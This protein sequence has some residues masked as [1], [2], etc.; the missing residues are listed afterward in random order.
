MVMGFWD[1]YVPGIG[2]FTGHGRI[3]DHWFQHTL[4]AHRTNGRDARVGQPGAIPNDVP[5][6]ID[7][8]I[9]PTTGTWREGFASFADFVGQTYHYQV[10]TGP[11]NGQDVGSHNDFAWARVVQEVDAGRPFFWCFDEHCVVGIGY[12]VDAAGA[13]WVIYLDTY[14]ATLTQ[15]LAEL[16]HTEGNGFTWLTL[17]AGD[18]P[19]DVTLLDPR[20]GEHVAASTPAAATWF[21]DG[22]A[23]SSADVSVSHDAGRSWHQIGPSFPAVS[24]FASFRWLPAPPQV[25]TRLRVRTFDHGAYLA[26]D[27]S[28]TDV[29]CTPQTIGGHW[30]AISGPVDGVVA[31]YD[32]HRGTRTIFTTEPGTGDV[33]QFQGK[34]GAVW[35]WLRVGGPGQAF[36]LDGSGVLYGLSP[37]G[38]GIWRY[39]GVG[40]TWT[41]IGGP[42]VAIHPDVDGV[43]AIEPGTGDLLRYLGTPFSWRRVG[44]PGASFAVDGKGVIYGVSPDHGALWRYTGLFGAVVPWTK[45]SGPTTQVF[46]RGLGVYA[47]NPDGTIRFF[48]GQPDVWTQVGGPGKAFTVDTEG[49]LYGLSSN[50]DGVWRYEG[51]ATDPTHWTKIGGAAGLVCAGHREVLA[52]NPSTRELWAYVE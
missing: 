14:G 32:K 41:H 22:T 15:K 9:D 31:G 27:G 11:T 4:W 46:A 40:T 28:V 52:T 47:T 39:G 3:V 35:N 8:L 13:K 24:G 36:V 30:V 44:G 33:Y 16:P 48:H 23:A 49:R 12:R 10:A 18:S 50:G 6:F 19:A 25:Q 37:G 26:G 1:H 20:G 43:L 34:P 29:A 7:E 38:Q 17:A 45:V 51:C 5:A 2:R 42:A 21:V